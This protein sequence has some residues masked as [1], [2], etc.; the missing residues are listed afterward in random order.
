M[1]TAEN[2]R[3]LHRCALW[4]SYQL[5]HL[6][7]NREYLCEGNDEICLRNTS[8]LLVV[9]LRVVK[10]SDIRL[11]ALLLPLQEGVLRIFIALKN[12]S[13]WLCLNLRTWVQWQ[14]H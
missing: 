6:V 2:C 4:Q 12:S 7:A 9:L 11:P 1:L 10:S 14:A 8:F 3:Y 13:P 5:S